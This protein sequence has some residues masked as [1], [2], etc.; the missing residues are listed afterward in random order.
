MSV[1]GWVGSG[2]HPVREES[3]AETGGEESCASGH[4][5]GDVPRMPRLIPKRKDP[6][7]PEE[8][9]CGKRKRPYRSTGVAGLAFFRERGSGVHGERASGTEI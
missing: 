8:R 7:C 4:H 1:V 3:D 5:A 9:F 2:E 6:V